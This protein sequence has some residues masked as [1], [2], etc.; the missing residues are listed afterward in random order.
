[1]PS[2]AVIDEVPWLVEQDRE[3][4]GALQAVWDR[5][6]SAAPVLLILVG[7]Q[8]VLASD[9]PLSTKPDNKNKRYR[10]A[11]PYLRFWLAFLER[12]IPLVAAPAAA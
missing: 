4:E 6:L 10:I 9:M 3:F 12:G 8:R 1:M 11:D 7:S 2:I 5:Y